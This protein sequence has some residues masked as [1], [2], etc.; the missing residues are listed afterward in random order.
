[1]LFLLVICLLGGI[2]TP[3]LA[4]FTDSY[5][6]SEDVVGFS[7][8]FNLAIDNIEEYE[9]ISVGAKEYLKFNVQITNVYSEDLFYGIW[10]KVVSS[11]K[12]DVVISRLDGTD[13]STSG[14]LMKD[15]VKVVTIIAINNGDEDAVIDFGILSDIESVNNIEYLDG[16]KL[17]S[18]VVSEPKVNIP[19][20]DSGMIP[21]IYDEE[22]ELWVKADYNNNSNSNSNSWYDYDNKMWANAVLVSD[23]S[24]DNYKKANVG[25]VIMDEDI[26]AF[27]VWIP[28]FKYKVW[29]LNRQV[30]LES[31]YAYSSY[32]N[33]IEIEFET[34]DESSGN[35][36]CVYDITS[37]ENEENLS[38]VCTYKVVDT[39]ITTSDNK[40]YDDAWY[41]H[42]AFTFGDEQVTGFWIGK[43]EVG[44]SK[45]S[46]LIKADIKS[47]VGENV[48]SQFSIAKTF[49]NYGLS[50]NI[51]AHMITNLEWGALVYLTHSK[52][53][54]CDSLVCRDVYI[55]NSSD[56]YT[57]RSGGDVAGS[58]NLSLKKIYGD[59][60]EELNYSSSGYYDY[61]GYF[62]EKDGK[63]T[64]EKNPSKVASTTGNIYGV[65]DVVGGAWE[66]SLGNML[67]SSNQFNSSL[68]GNAWDGVSYLSNKYYNSYSYGENSSSEG[69]FNRARLG[70][71]TSEVILKDQDKSFVW[72][73][74]NLDFSFVN[75]SNSWFL[76]GGD[77]TGNL[78]GSFTFDSSDGSYA[79]RNVAIRSSMS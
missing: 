43:Y 21:V 75:G 35:I 25:E 3:T 56:M 77:Y 59:E 10:Y 34:N 5:T 8:D 33:G 47:L 19:K 15:E 17:I 24:R 60:Y 20:L 52:Y 18:G 65:Y 36:S 13:I 71:A 74:G 68:A 42:P 44:G 7:F 55:N 69:A 39:V 66:A 49:Q 22:K 72:Y 28:R 29:N 14:V 26:L 6:T 62:I 9:K 70:D 64:K 27:Y 38:D 53:G 58:D 50:K 76:R 32:T 46:P 61:K 31:D 48:S 54:L 67:N 51:N 79:L 16:R 11:N 41:T 37:V 40:D 73:G 78:S 2:I 1:M 12:D 4:K 45:T 63:V 30:S 23:S 57:G